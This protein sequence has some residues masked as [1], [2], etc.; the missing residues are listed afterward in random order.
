[1]RRRWKYISIDVDIELDE[2][3]S[4]MDINDCNEMVDRLY[5][6]GF[7]EKYIEKERAKSFTS[8][9]NRWNWKEICEKLSD[10]QSRLTNE[11]E[12]II[13]KIADKL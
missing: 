4:Q 2:I 6:D 9:V 5:E 8:P 10:N 7:L 3:Y 11:E 12:E 13:K 1:M